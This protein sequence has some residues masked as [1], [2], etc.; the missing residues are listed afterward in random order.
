MLALEIPCPYPPTPTAR[1]FHFYSPLSPSPV[2]TGGMTKIAKKLRRAKQGPFESPCF[3][4]FPGD[5][6]LNNESGTLSRRTQ[7]IANGNGKLSISVDAAPVWLGEGNVIAISSKSLSAPLRA[8]APLN[9]NKC[10]RGADP[11]PLSRAAVE[12]GDTTKA[13]TT[14]SPERL[15]VLATRTLWVN[16][17]ARSSS[18]PP[19]TGVITPFSLLPPSA[20]SY[21]NVV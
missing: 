1:S 3:S 17:V 16:T 8:P 4:N 13:S 12:D 7:H 5:L 20:H 19:S 14:Q 9:P 21:V 10:F 15:P 11:S 18:A 6:L 2:V